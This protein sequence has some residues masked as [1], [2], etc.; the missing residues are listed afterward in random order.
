VSAA[1]LILRASAASGARRW[2]P[3]VDILYPCKC[4][5]VTK[6]GLHHRASII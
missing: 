1:R 3:Q 6:T 4:N 5:A 2:W